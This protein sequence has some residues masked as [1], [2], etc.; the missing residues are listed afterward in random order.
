MIGEL[1][2]ENETLKELVDE[3]DKT[4]AKLEVKLEQA[5]ARDKELVEEIENIMDQMNTMQT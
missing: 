4:K 3:Y 5:R 2:F 1:Q